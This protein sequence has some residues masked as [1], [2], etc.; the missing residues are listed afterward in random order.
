MQSPLLGGQL[1]IVA[2]FTSQVW[3]LASQNKVPLHGSPSSL[4]M[5]SPSS[6]H[7]QG[8][9]P[10]TQAPS[11]QRRLSHGAELWGQSGST[12][13]S[14]AASGASAA[15]CWSAATD[16][17]TASGSGG[18]GCSDWTSQPTAKAASS[19]TPT[20]AGNR[21]RNI[22]QTSRSRRGG[23]T[24]QARDA[25]KSWRQHRRRRFVTWSLR[26]RQRT[27]TQ[28][29]S[30][31][32]AGRLLRLSHPGR[33]RLRVRV[34]AGKS[35]DGR[36]TPRMSPVCRQ[37]HALMTPGVLWSPPCRLRPPKSTKEGGER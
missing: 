15:D 24:W 10:S 22:R 16:A 5:Q 4:A 23:Q 31:S 17:S 37:G 35:A 12:L 27:E 34:F 33:H 9:G 29:L 18:V 1:T 25:R 7:S 6:T 11:T 14:S 36:D 20:R 8:D 32:G 21:A 30:V 19:N 26:R 3:L 2:G 13:H 28:A